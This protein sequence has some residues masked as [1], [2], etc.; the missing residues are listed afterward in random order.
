M[1]GSGKTRT[2]TLSASRGSLEHGVPPGR[3][4]LLTFTNKAAKEMLRRVESLLPTDVSAIWGGTF[5]HIGNRILR[6]HAKL[7]GYGTDFTIL[8]R[9][10][11]K[12]MLGFVH[13]WRQA[14]L[15]RKRSGFPKGDVLADIY[16]LAV[17]TDR[18]IERVLA[19]EQYDYFLASRRG[20]SNRFQKMF[21]DR[22]AE[23]ERDGL[24]RSAR[25]YVAAVS[26]TGRGRGTLRREQFLHVLVDE[27]QDNEQDSGGV[28]RRGGDGAS[29]L[30]GGGRRCA[31][32]SVSVAR[33]I[34]NILGFAT[35]YPG[36]R[37]FK[38]E[39]NYR[40]VPSILNL[41]NEAIRANV[42]Q[43]AKNLMAVREGGVKPWLIPLSRQQSAIAVC[44]AA[45]YGIT[46]RR[47]G[48]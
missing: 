27:Y 46:G 47:R 14:L 15:I 8:D 17:N 34:W 30:D 29:Q 37:T 42:N 44:G 25:E 39:V 5:H 26:R 13:C 1:R 45:H 24:R 20:K 10:D 21:S 23:G 7:L 41:A 6:R 16:S 2:L 40:S 43:F 3:I 35:R 28:D 4:L 18:S 36:A 38:I 12:D 19:V 33:T 9:E 31:V 22:K 32:D 48:T 11:S